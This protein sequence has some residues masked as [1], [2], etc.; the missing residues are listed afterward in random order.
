MNSGGSGE[1]VDSGSS[2]HTDDR[3]NGEVS[4]AQPNRRAAAV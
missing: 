1:K 4:A 2:G 3:A